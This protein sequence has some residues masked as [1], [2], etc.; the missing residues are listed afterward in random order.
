M[1]MSV[2]KSFSPINFSTI[3]SRFARPVLWCRNCDFGSSCWFVVRCIAHIRTTGRQ[4]WWP[5]TPRAEDHWRWKSFIMPLWPDSFNSI[6]R[7]RKDVVQCRKAGC[8]TEWVSSCNTGLLVAAWLNVVS[9]TFNIEMEEVPQNWVC[10]SCLSS[11]R[12]ARYRS[13]RERVDAR[14]L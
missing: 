5:F 4:R 12:P 2:D 13:A 3:A 9:I 11:S 14:I 6:D 7:G 8:E 1:L 10:V